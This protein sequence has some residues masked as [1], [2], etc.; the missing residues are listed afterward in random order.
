MLNLKDEF[1][2]IKQKYVNNAGF[3]YVSKGHLCHKVDNNVTIFNIKPIDVDSNFLVRIGELTKLDDNSYTQLNSDSTIDA[4]YS[5]DFLDIMFSLFMVSKEMFDFC[6]TIVS[7]GLS[8]LDIGT[9][10]CTNGIVEIS[11]FN[12]EYAISGKFTIPNKTLSLNSF[13]NFSIIY[14]IYSFYKLYSVKKEVFNLHIGKMPSNR[15]VIKCYTLNIDFNCA[16]IRPSFINSLYE[17]FN[18]LLHETQLKKHDVL[19]K[20]FIQDNYPGIYRNVIKC[21]GDE[22]KF[23]SSDMFN[24]LVDGDISVMVTKV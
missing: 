12:L 19:N 9:I 15:Y 7:C 10:K 24:I 20:K 11:Y 16:L 23:Y 4:S 1:N 6:N 13:I 5:P 14:Y 3:L 22:I 18:T 17:K 21:L 8:P 2:I